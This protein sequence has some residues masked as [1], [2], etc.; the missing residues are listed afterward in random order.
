M[1]SFGHVAGETGRL[2]DEHALERGQALDHAEAEVAHQ[3]QDVGAVG[4]QPIQSVGGDAHGHGVEA[5]PALIALEH[6]GR[7]DV[8]PEPGG[9]GDCLRQGGDVAQAHVESLPGDRMNDVRGVADQRQTIGDERARG[10]QA[11]RKSA[12]RP[13]HLD[14]AELQ[15]EA[16][17]QF[18]VKFLIGQRDDALGLTRGLGPND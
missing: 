7:A 13:D 15:A 6:I 4:E 12:A 8:E 18:G 2:A 14:I 9:V 16:F 17:F 11:E 3:T 5:A 1:S 10:E